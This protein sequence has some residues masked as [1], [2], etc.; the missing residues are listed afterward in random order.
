MANDKTLELKLIAKDMM[1]AVVEGAQKS[2]GG[3]AD[4]V[5]SGAQK[6]AGAW[7]AAVQ[8]INKV[9]DGYDTLS[10]TA[11]MA[12]SALQTGWNLL[13]E[14]GLEAAR[15]TAQTEAVIAST[16][17]AA[18]L[19]AEEIGNMAGAM[20]RVSGV[21]D[22]A[23]QG[24]ANVLL[25][26]TEIS[27]SAFP[28]A[29]AAINDMAVAMAGGDVAGADLA[30]TAQLLG[31][32][33]SNPEQGISQLE[34]SV[35]KFSDAEKAS[36][37]EM[38]A[39]NDI[40]GAQAVILDKLEKKFGGAAKAAGD[41]L[42][43]QMAKAQNA[44][45]NFQENVANTFI[46]IMGAAA[47]AFNTLTTGNQQLADQFRASQSKM[48]TDLIAGKMTLADY[49]A[50]IAGMAQSV[51]QW[52][53][54]TGTA[55][56]QQYAWNQAQLDG[57][58]ANQNAEAA[59]RNL[60]QAQADAVA[61]YDVMD[62]GAYI[63]A[64]DSAAL[65]ERGAAEAVKAKAAAD[66]EAKIQADLN[67]EAIKRQA[68]AA[69]EN[70]QAIINYGQAV[71]GTAQSLKDATDAEAKQALAKA[72]LD[73]LKQ[74]RDAG[75]ISDNTYLV[76]LQSMQLQYGLATEKS[77]AMGEAQ[78]TLNQLLIDGAIPAS[79][80]VTGIGKIPQAAADG[81]INLGELVTGGVDPAKLAMLDASTATDTLRDAIIKLPKEVTIKINIETEGALPNMA[82]AGSGGSS[83]TG[84]GKALGGPVYAGNP[85]IVGDNGREPFVPAVDGRIL[86]RRDALD[87]L[88]RSGGSSAPVINLSI[89]SV[90]LANPLDIEDFTWRMSEI[91]A[92]RLQAL[93]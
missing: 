47:E 83:K 30:G 81:K 74:A 60:A 1:S 21:S 54:A 59:A 39:H 26:F 75:T 80:Y 12:M 67:A 40:A 25:R 61:I 93:Q 6:A 70:K 34:R 35:G 71:A 4:A 28:R 49:N 19:T 27:G 69:E 77:L 85:Y 91:L 48:Q 46:P 41:T 64:A 65:A 45:E 56:L 50:G 63:S 22:E 62:R 24:A 82:G 15:V 7:P 23:A 73:A 11:G 37:K 76:S 55:L 53:K 89:A 87:A 16:G 78:A 51:M 36:I 43:G 52:D 29:T 33:L 58:I 88:S 38:M 90:T 3:L 9:K 5:K 84:S 18:G 32:A 72:G 31:K 10:G 42:P 44:I 20:S 17:G 2:V 92:Q 57:V 86:S 8:G 14:P 66:A 79:D 13:I 68:Q